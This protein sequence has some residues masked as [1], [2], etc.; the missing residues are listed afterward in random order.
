[1]ADRRIGVLATAIVEELLAALGIQRHRPLELANWG[2]Q[3]QVGLNP[4]RLVDVTLDT[5]QSVAI[6]LQSL[7][8][9]AVP[10][11]RVSYGCGTAQRVVI[12][13]GVGTF[14]VAGRS[15][16]VDALRSNLPWIASAFVSPAAVP[17]TL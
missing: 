11:F 14:I 15:I 6:V 4:Q 2:N 16:Q 5:P 1:V 17:P 13:V 9:A 12:G 8:P 7:T 3:V 10:N